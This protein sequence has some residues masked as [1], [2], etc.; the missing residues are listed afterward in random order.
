MLRPRFQF[1]LRTLFVAVTVAATF[2]YVPWYV[3]DCEYHLVF[4]EGGF[5]SVA[6]FWAMTAMGYAAWRYVLAIAK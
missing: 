5:E 3:R 2:A 4:N 6:A 1:S